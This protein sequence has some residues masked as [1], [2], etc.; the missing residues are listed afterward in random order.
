MRIL[1]FGTPQFAAPTLAALLASRHTVV[2]VVTQPDRAR[3][4]V[5]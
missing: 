5:A 2:A 1:Y 3:D 4:R